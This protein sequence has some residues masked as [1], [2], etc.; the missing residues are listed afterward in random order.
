MIWEQRARQRKE[1][2]DEQRS[3]NKSLL[4]LNQQQEKTIQN[5]TQTL[6]NQKKDLFKIQL[7]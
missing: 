2:L 1:E 5:L 3:K 4:Q 6:E 7:N